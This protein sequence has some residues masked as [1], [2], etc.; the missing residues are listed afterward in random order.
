MINLI[1]VRSSFVTT[2]ENTENN[3]LMED[4]SSEQGSSK[5]NRNA[6]RRSTENI[7][8]ITIDDDDDDDNDIEVRN[9][10]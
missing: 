5:F 4:D 8:F 9:C 2:A 6:S 10:F 3:M 7:E 1:S